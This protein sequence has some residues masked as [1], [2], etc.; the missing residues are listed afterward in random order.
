VLLE[1]L[2]EPQ[3]AFSVQ[4]GVGVGVGVRVGVGV[5]VGVGVL[6]GGTVGVPN[7]AIVGVGDNCATLGDT[8]GDG[9]IVGTGDIVGIG[10]IVG[11]G[12]NE[13]NG[14]GVGVGPDEEPPVI[15]RATW[16]FRPS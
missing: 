15:T 2:P 12:D 4:G 8:V 14:V 1:Q 7:G 6:T 10:E 5:A 13:I 11:K 16:R 3:L 9:G